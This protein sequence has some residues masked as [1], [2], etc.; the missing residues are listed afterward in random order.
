MS[1]RYVYS[2]T[3]AGQAYEAVSRA[4]EAGLGDKEISLIARSDIE[5]DAIPDELKSAETDLVP[6]AARGAGYGAVGGALAGLAAAVFPPVGVTI[7]GAMIGGGTIGAMV[8]SWSSALAGSTVPDPVRRQFESR[9]EA[10]QVLVVIDAGEPVQARLA[11][12]FAEAG[13]ERLLYEPG[14]APA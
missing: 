13:L 6:A 14:A 12:L 5:L 9:I 1:S 2:A 4:R 7:A 8:G 10:G 3:T 11:P